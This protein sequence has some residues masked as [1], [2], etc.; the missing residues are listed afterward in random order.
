MYIKARPH[1]GCYSVGTVELSLEDCAVDLAIVTRNVL[2]PYTE[3]NRVMLISLHR[4]RSWA[5]FEQQL[6]SDQE[7]V[8]NAASILHVLATKMYSCPVKLPFQ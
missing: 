7:E 1:L 6:N 4:P 3:G 2:L 8:L 5:R